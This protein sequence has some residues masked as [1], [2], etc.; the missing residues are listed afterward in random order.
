MVATLLRRLVSDTYSEATEG[1]RT[2]RSGEQSVFGRESLQR[3]A[4]CYDTCGGNTG[5][6]RDA[7]R[8]YSG[9]LSFQSNRATHKYDFFFSFS[10][11]T[12]R[13]RSALAFF[14]AVNVDPPFPFPFAPFSI[15]SC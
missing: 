12:A 8:A 9:F 2:T 14:F 11:R 5:G 7:Q 3:F 6:Y 1:R 15:S 13:N 4:L 10:M